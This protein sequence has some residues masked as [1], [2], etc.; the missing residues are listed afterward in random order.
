[1]IFQKTEK[2]RVELRPGVRTLSQRERTFLLLVDG[3]RSFAD[4]SGIFAE[5]AD[6][7]VAKLTA[8]GYLT[9]PKAEKPSYVKPSGATAKARAGSDPF[10]GKRSLTTVR[11]FLFDMC[12]RM[13]VRKDPVQAEF[14]REALRSA[15]DRASMLAAGRLMID[16]IEKIAGPERA[17]SIRERIAMML[18]DETSFESA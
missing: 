8:A 10:D 2:A 9:A 11:M 3:K 12:E 13:F 14:F 16:E 6:S 5:D 1:M 4:L 18:P 7:L 17:D 15:R